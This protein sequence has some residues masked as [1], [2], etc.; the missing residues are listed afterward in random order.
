M[1]YLAPTILALALI[2][3]APTFAAADDFGVHPT[4]PQ[5]LSRVAALEAMSKRVSVACSFAVSKPVVQVGEPFVL[6]WGSYGAGDPVSGAVSSLVPRGEQTIVLDRPG[7]MMYRFTFTGPDG[8]TAVCT[9]RI[10]VVR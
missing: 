5:L 8:T 9:P 2:V 6:S 4:V 7:T 3:S 10:T 1:K